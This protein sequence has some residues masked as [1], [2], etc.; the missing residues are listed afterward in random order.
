MYKLSV[1]LQNP[2]I[3]FVETELAV[4]FDFSPFSF[5]VFGKIGFNY[6]KSQFIQ[7]FLEQLLKVDY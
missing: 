3:L 2:F 1:R 5:V 4:D 6:Q 7:W